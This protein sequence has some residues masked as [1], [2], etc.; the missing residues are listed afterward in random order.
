[1]SYRSR[2]PPYFASSFLTIGLCIPGAVLHFRPDSSLFVASRTVPVDIYRVSHERTHNS[3]LKMHV[4]TTFLIGLIG[5]GAA[6]GF[7]QESELEAVRRE[8]KEAQELFRKTVEQQ[9]RLIESLADKVQALEAKQAPATNRVASTD[10]AALTNAATAATSGLA[11]SDWSP[12]DPVRLLGSGRNYLNLSFD[13]LFA[14]GSSTAREVEALEPGGHDPKQRG[15]TVQN[16]EAIVD[17]KVDP[18]FR[19]QANVVMTIDPDGETIV[20]AEEAYLETVALPWNLQVKAG[21]YLTEFGRMNATH[22]H[23]WGFVDQ[24][25]VN[26]RLLGSDGLRNP[27]ARI[28]WLVPTPFYS[29]LLLSVQN[30][31]GDTAASFRSRGVHSHGDNGNELPFALRHS[32]NDRGVRHI[33]DLLFAP[34][35]AVS[36]DV[37][38]SQT[39]LFGASAAFGPNSSGAAGDTRSQV[40]GVDLTWKWKPA[41]QAGGYPF[42]AWQTEAMMRRFKAGA[43]DWDENGNGSVDAGELADLRT[44]APAVLRSETLADYGIYSQVLYGFRKGWV[45]GLRGDYVR[46][47][48]GDYERFLK[49]F[50]GGPAFT[51]DPARAARWRLSPNLTWFPTE[52]S[53]I[54][55]QYNYDRRREM[56]DD[57]SVWLQFEFLLGA[58]AAHAF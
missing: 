14:A 55:L 15:F 33:D 13:G 25:L 47:E 38:D 44:G 6:A 7:A 53:K 32:E 3:G 54:R 49:S 26:N 12:A 20:E 56:G 16:L 45:A 43:F 9:R 57:H 23:G 39:A 11:R 51:L 34:R 58:H 4:K 27:G 2:I 5:F 41:S 37:S 50:N 36:F 52:F 48:R 18:Y 19:G 22:P 17:G 10:S 24:P 1:M 28:S 30:S 40:Y 31:G 46:G 42:V 35:Y 21:Q 8:L 29:E